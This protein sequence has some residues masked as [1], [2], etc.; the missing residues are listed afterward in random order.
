M[1]GMA[2]G[3]AGRA[4]LREGVVDAGGVG[5]LVQHLASANLSLRLM[6]CGALLN[7]TASATAAAAVVDASAD[8]KLEGKPA[9]VPGLEMLVRRCHVTSY[10][11]WLAPLEMYDCLVLMAP[12]HHGT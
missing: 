6:A 3:E 7:A 4:T 10:R 5:L 2:G 1:S 11:P 9:S 8:T 12:W